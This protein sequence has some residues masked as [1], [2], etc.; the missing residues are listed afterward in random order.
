MDRSSL[1]KYKKNYMFIFTKNDNYTKYAWAIPL[2]A[3]SG[4][5]TTTALL[6]LIEKAKRKPHK[7][8]SDRGKDFYNKTFLRYLKEQN[9]QI[10]STN[11]DLQAVF[12]ER[13]N[14]TLLDLLKEPMYMKVKLVG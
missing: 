10:Y 7:I 4:K 6:S 3:K 8:W 13:F 14:R 1:S 2:K 5:C 9:I 12:V 11:S